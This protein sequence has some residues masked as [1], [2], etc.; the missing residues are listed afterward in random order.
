MNEL[1][2]IGLYNKKWDKYA[3]IKRILVLQDRIFGLTFLDKI[4][5]NGFTQTYV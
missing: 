5:L 1:A 3:I 2:C 4:A